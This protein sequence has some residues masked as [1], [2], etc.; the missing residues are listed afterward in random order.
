MSIKFGTYT[1]IDGLEM[2]LTEYYGHGLD[3]DFEQNHRI[4]SYP[5]VFGF[6]EG[7][8]LDKENNVYKKDILLKDL[9]NA[10]FVKTKLIFLGDVYDVWAFNKTSQKFTIYTTNDELGQKNNFIKLSD[11][12]IREVNFSEVKKLWEEYFPAPFKIAMP[13]GLELT[14]EIDVSSIA[15]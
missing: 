7:F 9:K 4:I 13:E 11:R 8:K 6:K 14:K 3:Q 15:S 12:F 1:L 10:F 2:I 5:A